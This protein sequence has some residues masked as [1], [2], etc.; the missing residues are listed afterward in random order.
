[1][2]LLGRGGMG[3]VYRADDLTLGQT[4]AL[5]FLPRGLTSDA[6]RLAR[7]RNEVRTAR[8]VSHPN[9]C[10]V[11]DIGEADGLPFLSM[12]YVT[13]EDLA[14]LLRRIG[15]LP[16]DKGIEIARQICAG[17]H[18][19]H[20]RGVA[21]RD[22]KPENVM[23]DE[24]GDV[25]LADFGLAGAADRPDKGIAGTPAYMA[26]EL[27]DGRAT[28]TRAD[29][30]ALGL[31][32]YEVFT[33][34]RMFA[35]QSFAELAQ[36]HRQRPPSSVSQ[37]VPE[38]D[39][40]IDGV[41]QQCVSK[42]P[43]RRPS[44]ALAV[45]A[46]LPGGDPLTAALARGETPSP[47]LVASAGG[48]GM[49]RPSILVASLAFVVAGIVVFAWASASTH[50][51]S[52]ASLPRSPDVL[53]D[54]AAA[55]V[56]ELGYETPPVDSASGF[57]LSSFVLHMIEQA[58]TGWPW[59]DAAAGRPSAVL[60]WYRQ[61]PAPLAAATFWSGGRIGADD[62]LPPVPGTVS[63]QLDSHGRLQA[64]VAVPDRVQPPQKSDEMA[65]HR[66]FAAAGLDQKQF[67]SIEPVLTPPV[68]ADR[69]AAWEGVYP[70]NSSVRI[71]LDAAGAN[72]RPVY[73]FV[74][75]PW[76]SMDTGMMALRGAVWQMLLFVLICIAG[77]ALAIRNLRL[78]RVDLAGATRLAAVLFLLR[79]IA[80]ALTADYPD[81]GSEFLILI[82]LLIAEA[83][84]L[85]ALVWI[86]YAA[87]EPH[88]RRRWPESLISWTRLISGRWRDPRVG[89][90]I[91]VGVTTAVAM[92]LGIEAAD[93]INI[94]LGLLTSLSVTT[95][96]MLD[97]WRFLIGGLLD[98][99][100]GAVLLA[101]ALLLL[102][103]MT[104]LFVRSRKLAMG[105]VVAAFLGPQLIGGGTPIVTMIVAVAVVTAA[106][107][108]LSRLGVLPLIVTV[109]CAT[110][111][112][113]QPLPLALSVWYAPFGWFAAACVVA[114]AC[115]GFYV[116]LA[117]RP[118]FAG[119]LLDD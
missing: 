79:V 33:G 62:P 35:D 115:Y 105:I 12:E 74:R 7:F 22:L 101:F 11:Y 32:L 61:S 110:A 8:E 29:I 44:S 40:S 9:V 89:R 70:E 81:G 98:R 94:R 54:R 57:M 111:L 48:E 14:S 104:T 20:E 58:K 85:S 68:F 39:R 50:L 21:H 92:L 67:T 37:I 10:R 42:D 28:G 116:A 72:G 56:R 59:T 31:V 119:S 55:I 113:E 108:M 15:R 117:G 103:L 6:D 34:R 118:V 13:G 18:A 60:F 76:T 93:H 19:A 77:L 27:F 2:A 114:L 64:F 84:F 4:V 52:V 86:G 47:A 109:I 43:D 63:L 38:I 41:I 26:P 1:V 95:P 112:D 88:V 83:L 99:P 53:R 96:E 97:G 87:L 106:V 16:R 71:R 73:F 80:R 46:A 100:T 66:L 78:G 30:Y 5:K 36:A 107:V 25:R 49:V 23:I 90:D 3:E 45:A 65:W 102:L 91:L 69:R 82:T 24:R 17:L 51:L 75:E